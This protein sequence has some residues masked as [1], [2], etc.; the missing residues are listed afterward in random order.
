M[1]KLCGLITVAMLVASTVSAAEV[2]SGVKT[3]TV[4]TKSALAIGDQALN[5]KLAVKIDDAKSDVKQAK[6]GDAQSGKVEQASAKVETS[7]DTST[8]P[9]TLKPLKRRI[10]VFKASWC[11]ACQFLNYE[12]P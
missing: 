4:S 11:S 6:A 5:L 7:Q 12:W 3:R 8:K 9:K 10:L 2:S 1:R